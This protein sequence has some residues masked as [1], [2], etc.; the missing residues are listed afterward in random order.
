MQTG[1]CWGKR[2]KG[3][4]TRNLAIVVRPH[5]DSLQPHA[6][7]PDGAACQ[8]SLRA[9]IGSEVLDKVGCKFQR[10]PCRMH[11]AGSH[12]RCRT[13]DRSSLQAKRRKRRA[14]YHLSRD[15]CLTVCQML[16]MFDDLRLDILALQAS[17]SSPSG[18]GHGSAARPPCFCPWRNFPLHP[19]CQ[20]GCCACTRTGSACH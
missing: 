11:S 3:R 2:P 4:A 5:H 20:V 7:L 17:P 18:Q 14:A 1:S 16:V 12:T 9:E 6:A 19:T 13:P 15:E 8:S 10:C